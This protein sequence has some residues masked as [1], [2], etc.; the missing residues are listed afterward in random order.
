MPFEEEGFEAAEQRAEEAKGSGFHKLNFLKIVDGEK[1]P[2]FI[3]FVTPKIYTFDV[4]GG[5]PTKAKPAEVNFAWPS[6]MFAICQNSRPFRL[7]DPESGQPTEEFEDGYGACHIH[8]IMK[9]VKNDRGYKGDKSTPRVQSYG[10]AA[11][12][13]PVRDGSGAITTFRDI[14]EEFKQEDGT[15]IRIPKLVLAQ[16]TYSN[17]WGPLKAQTYM[18]SSNIT[19]WDFG[20]TRKENDYTFSAR[21]TPNFHHQAAEWK[22]YTDALALT[23][24]NLWDT[25]INWSSPDWYKRWFIEG[26]TPEGGYGS[27]KGDETEGESTPAAAANQPS[28]EEVSSFGADLRAARSGAS[29]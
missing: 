18:G 24:T 9:G 14:T 5:I 27:G 11:L 7:R 12:R 8:L 6:Q 4:H 25:L 22:V 26:A 23:G 17:F 16:Q 1:Q 2:T 28:P 19:A 3:R 29:A 13:E 21:E 20:I 10:L 15:V